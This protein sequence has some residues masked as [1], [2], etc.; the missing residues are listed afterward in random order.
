MAERIPM[1]ERIILSQS[2]IK[3]LDPEKKGCPAKAK[4]IYIEGA[5]SEPSEAMQRGNYFETLLMGAPEDGIPVQMKRTEKGEKTV[6]QQRIERHVWNVNHKIKAEMGMDFHSPRKQLLVNIGEKYV[7]RARTD[8]VTSMRDKE[9]TIIPNVILDFKITESILSTFPTDFAWGLPHVMDHT[10][11]YAY[12]WA[13]QVVYKE[14]IPFYYLVMDVSTSAAWKFVGG[15]PNATHH[16]EFKE[17]LR[18]TIAMIEEYTEAGWP[19]NPSYD[20]CKRCPLRKQCPGFQQGADI[21]E[22]W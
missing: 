22:I 3:A 7:F 20:N 9:G 8:M 13:W 6:A 19:L 10:Q 15:I 16:A 18:R 14:R 12:T 17:S 1:S 11:A 4:A 21:Q 2:F 5:K